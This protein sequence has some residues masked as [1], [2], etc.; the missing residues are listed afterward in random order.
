MNTLCPICGQRNDTTGHTCWV[1][2]IAPT[3]WNNH[4]EI[5]SDNTAVIS[6][7]EQRIALLE[8]EVTEQARLL[9]DSGST[10]ARL[11]TRIKELEAVWEGYHARGDRVLQLEARIALLEA[12]AETAAK[13]HDPNTLVA[14]I[15]EIEDSLH[16]A[17]RAAGYLKEQEG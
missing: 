17:L 14:D 11:N 3:A 8:A 16:K 7:L 2:T 12:V 13:F 15:L 4:H 1:Q 10:E 9:G 6:A 5:R